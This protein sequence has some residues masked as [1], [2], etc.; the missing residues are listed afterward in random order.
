MD[1]NFDEIIDR[2]DTR[3]IKWD[4]AESDVLPMWIADMDFKTAPAIIH[5]LRERVEHGVFGYTLTPP[6]FHQAIIRWWDR[7]Y[8]F[9]PHAEGIIPITGVLPALSVI[10]EALTNPGDRI[11]LQPPV[12]N[13]FFVAADHGDR[14]ILENNLIYENGMY[15]ID[16]DDLEQ[17]AADPTARLLLLCNPHNPAG[18]VWTAEELLRIGEICSRNHVIVVSDEIHADLVYAG[19]RHTPFASLGNATGSPSITVSSP[20]KTFNLAGLQVG[21]LYT[22]HPEWK[23]R[24]EQVMKKRELLLLNPFAIAALLA[25]YEHGEDWLE[26]LK[27]YLADNFNYLSSFCATHINGVT[28]TPL[29]A[30]YLAWLDCRAFG[31]QATTFAERALEEERLWINSGA[32]YGQAGTG[33]LRINIACPRVLLVDGL[34]RL[35]SVCAEQVR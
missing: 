10:M 17:K 35:A 3:S 7:R 31:S 4:A 20:S 11:I 13:H 8:G 32:M 33:F 27:A 24:I 29:Q 26:A 22:E 19:H 23:K 18:R 30:T 5:A 2:R 16:F 9:A 14:Q 28:V 25:A 6:E 1:Y 34:S 12:Y 21:Y 15:R